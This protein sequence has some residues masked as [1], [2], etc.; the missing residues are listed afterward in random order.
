MPTE[1][2]G[3]V[4]LRVALKRFAPDLSKETQSQMAAALKI[5]PV[6]SSR[7]TKPIIAAVSLIDLTIFASAE[8]LSSTNPSFKTR[9]SGGY[10]VKDNSGKA[11]ISHL[12]AIA[13][14]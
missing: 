4:Q 3:A 8:R 14:L 13:W 2:E 6:R 5:S 9:S 12:A 7:S 10:P 11:T 1:L